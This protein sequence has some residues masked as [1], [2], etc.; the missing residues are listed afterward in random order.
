MMGGGCPMMGMMGRG[1]MNRGQMG[2]GM[3]G[4]GMRRRG[5]MGAMTEGRLAFLKAELKITE[6]QEPAWKEYSDAAKDRVSIMQGM[7]QGM[8]ESMQNGTAV[9]RME[10]R[11]NGME[12]MLE[13]MKAVKPA[14]DKLYGALTEEQKMVADELI[15]MDCGAM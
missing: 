12:A 3:M 15:G 7:R 14:A 13:S 9:E 6:T 8:M 4:G 1:M 11:I 2:R 10:A 5:G